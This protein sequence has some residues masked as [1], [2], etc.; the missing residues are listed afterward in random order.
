MATFNA[1]ELEESY[2]HTSQVRCWYDWM[3][4]ELSMVIISLASPLLWMIPCVVFILF[5]R[6]CVVPRIA[7]LG[8]FVGLKLRITR[9]VNR[10]KGVDDYSATD[11]DIPFIDDEEDEVE[12]NE[13]LPK[14]HE[15]IRWD[16][17]NE[18]SAA[19]KIVSSVMFIL[20]EAHYAATLLCLSLLHCVREEVCGTYSGR[21]YVQ[22]MPWLQCVCRIAACPYSPSNDSAG[23]SPV[24]TEGTSRRLSLA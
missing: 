6:L 23:V 14:Q 18:A 7:E 16:A 22:S 4:E 13:I 5:C 8:V 11:H 2:I 9:M 24:T 21:S 1:V 19:H 20:Y 10:W 3:H 15:A 17:R 12:A